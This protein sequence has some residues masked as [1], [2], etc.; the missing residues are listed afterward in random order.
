MS[1]KQIENND[2]SNG[3]LRVKKKKKDDKR[4][5]HTKYA[6]NEQIVKYCIDN[7][8]L[9]AL[10]IWLEIDLDIEILRGGVI[11]SY[12][13]ALGTDGYYF[14]S[15][16]PNKKRIIKEIEISKNEY[17]DYLKSLINELSVYLTESESKPASAKKMF[18]KY[19]YTKLNHKK[20]DEDIELEAFIHHIKKFTDIKTIKEAEEN[21]LIS[22]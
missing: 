20:C 11:K 4:K 1:K 17:E 19:V 21:N 15:L 5:I 7:D 6:S 16:D 10:M 13:T 8:L 9:Y 14:V 2:E 3:A 12:K 22:K 18:G